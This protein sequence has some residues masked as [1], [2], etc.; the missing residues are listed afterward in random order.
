MWVVEWMTT[1]MLDR[2]IRNFSPVSLFY[3]FCNP[4][5]VRRIEKFTIN[6]HDHDKE[7]K[8]GRQKHKERARKAKRGLIRVFCI[9]SLNINCIFF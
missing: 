9:F 6:V 7:T 5:I 4:T 1:R 2:N 8:N 3:A